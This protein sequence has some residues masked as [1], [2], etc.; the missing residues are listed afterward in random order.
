MSNWGLK[1]AHHRT[2]PQPA[3][4]PAEAVTITPASKSAPAKRKP[5]VTA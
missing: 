4:P 1:R 5:K 3:A 2:W